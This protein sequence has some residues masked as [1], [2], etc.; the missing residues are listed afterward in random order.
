M[1]NM[2]KFGNASVDDMFITVDQD[3]CMQNLF[4]TLGKAI[5]A[6]AYEKTRIVKDSI[7]EHTPT[8]LK[9]RGRDS[10]VYSLEVKSCPVCK[11]VTL[12][13]MNRPRTIELKVA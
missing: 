6:V 7:I 1:E 9:W 5:D 12:D 3:G 2:K 4:A 8:M 10:L 13:Y 11:D